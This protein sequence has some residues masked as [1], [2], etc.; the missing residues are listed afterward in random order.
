MRNGR[1][2]LRGFLLSGLA[3]AI[4][5][6]F[7][8][9][10]PACPDAPEPPAAV[11]LAA[12][13]GLAY[14]DTQDDARLAATALDA[15]AIQFGQVFGRS[16]PPGLLVLSS[17]V[18]G[19]DAERFAQ[20]HDLGF[21]QSWLSPADKR[22]QIE[23]V[24]RRATPD[25]D[26]AR[27]ETIL[28]QVEAQHVDLLRHELGHAQ[29]RAAFW[30]DATPSP[31]AYGTPAPDWLDEASAVLMEGSTGRA[32]RQRHFLEAWRQ[33]SPAIRPLAEFLTMAHPVTAQKRALMQ[34]QGGTQSASGVQV[35]TMRGPDAEAGG[36]FYSQSL[37]FA[38]FLIDAS[39][40]PHILAT[41]SAAV[42][43]GVE[44][45][46]WLAATGAQHG[47][48]TDLADLQEAWNAWCD[49]RDTAASDPAG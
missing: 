32:S 35:M 29:Y 27:I 9:G 13:H 19:D 30:P 42:A 22:A 31:D 2:V 16:L 15:A 8:A 36:M 3:A 12:A 23:I 47:L 24:I 39:S 17:T 20:T 5:A 21:A 33:S 40:D 10:A 11:C 38:D 25:A 43:S 26:A 14:A 44:F 37:L 4:P 1:E 6:A 48:P 34:A 49:A 45:T 28:S 18:S 46:D 7:A 41:I